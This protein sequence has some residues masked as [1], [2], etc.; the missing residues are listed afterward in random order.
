MA[1]ED[2]SQE[3]KHDYLDKLRTLEFP[4][5]YTEVKKLTDA[6]AILEEDFSLLFEAVE[7]NRFEYIENFSSFI[8]KDFEQFNVGIKEVIDQK[9][10]TALNLLEDIAKFDLEFAL[11]DLTR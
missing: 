7:T 8:Q 6:S 3:V 10:V 11:E 1:V 4:Y 9:Q 2:K 5:I